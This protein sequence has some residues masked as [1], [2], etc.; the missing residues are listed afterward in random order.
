MSIDAAALDTKHKKRD[1]H[2]R[3]T[4]FFDVERHPTIEFVA[5]EI[6]PL[7]TTS[8]E[9]KGWLTVRGV[10]KPVSFTANATAISEKGVTLAT[11]LTFDRTHYG[12]TWNQMGMLIG[13]AE[14]TI[15]LRFTP[16]E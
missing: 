12:M 6:K 5:D 10:T 2:L 9:I 14:L 13:L 3:S 15:S 11:A 7:G 8:V 1:I 4:D 16:A